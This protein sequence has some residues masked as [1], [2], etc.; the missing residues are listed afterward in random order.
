VRRVLASWP[1]ACADLAILDP[2]YGLGKAHWDAAP[3][4][5]A[6]LLRDVIRILKPE[7][8]A[9]IFGPPETIAR[10]WAEFPEPK[11]LLTWA[12]SNRVSPS[13]RTWQS[14]TET[15]VMCWKG[16]A[17][18][19]DRDAVREPYSESA[20][21]QRGRRRP[22][23]PGRF[24]GTVT[25]YSTAE[26]ALPRD[27]LRGPGLTGST[28][29]REGLGHNCQKPT[30]LMERLIKASCPTGGLVIDLFAGTATA[31]AS[32]QRLGRKWIAIEN[33]AHWC[34]VALKRLHDAGATDATICEPAGPQ[35]LAELLA[36]KASAEQ[37]LARLQAAVAALT[38]STQGSS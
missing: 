29:A 34:D 8:T 14:T 20:E 16:G 36:W 37:E 4:Y 31:A 7:G 32:A 33:D 30:W 26:G 25:T 6:V 24:G 27:V 21:R 9:Y 2:A 3:D 11:R 18:F 23:T 35:Q 17:P 13:V 1:D 19:F 22:P 38:D 15:I 28:G 12:V 5:D 10:N